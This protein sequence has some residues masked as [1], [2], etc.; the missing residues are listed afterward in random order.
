MAPLPVRPPK[1]HPRFGTC[2]GISAAEPSR[3]GRAFRSAGSHGPGQRNADMSLPVCSESKY[4][5]RALAGFLLPRCVEGRPTHVHGSKPLT[6]PINAFQLGF[7]R[8][9]PTRPIPVGGLCKKLLQ[10]AG[11]GQYRGAV[12][13]K[14]HCGYLKAA[15]HLPQVTRAQGSAQALKQLHDLVAVHG[16]LSAG[17]SVVDSRALG[18]RTRSSSHATPNGFH[19]PLGPANRLHRRS[20]WKNRQSSRRGQIRLAC[21]ES[22]PSRR[23]KGKIRI[24]LEGGWFF[25]FSRINYIPKVRRL[26]LTAP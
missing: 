22:P 16:R 23:G 14:E 21:H 15:R 11:I 10:L 9:E 5:V 8:D 25:I 26:C 18:N 12:I 6:Q 2:F 19:E 24:I 1:G 17:L 4:V 7:C 3:S 13:G 20:A